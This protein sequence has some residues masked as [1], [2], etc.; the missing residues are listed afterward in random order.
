MRKSFRGL[1]GLVRQHLDADP[2]SGHIFC[3]LNRRK[4]M[5]KCLVHDRTGFLIYY[6][7]LSRGTFQFPEVSDGVTRAMID[8]GTLTLILEGIDL[9]SV[10]RRV[11][12]HR[13][14]GPPAES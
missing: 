5:L 6:K 9:K 3:F 13:H 1:S 10:K 8:A 2:L 14:F 11:R 7:K 4:N 12:H